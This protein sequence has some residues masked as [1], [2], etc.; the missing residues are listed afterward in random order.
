MID[1]TLGDTL[2]YFAD[3]Q[4][5]LHDEQQKNWAPIIQ[6]INSQYQL[7]LVPTESSIEQP[8]L[9]QQTKNKLERLL[10]THKF[11]TILAL[12]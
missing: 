10:L 11:T 1:Y 9:T 2:L 4:T 3:P 12:R 8:R 6:W 5:T 7:D